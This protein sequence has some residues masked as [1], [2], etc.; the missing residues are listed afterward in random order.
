[1]SER[2]LAIDAGQSSVTARVV[3]DERQIELPGVRTDSAL[4][5][6]LAD[7]V[8]AVVASVGSVGAVAIGTTGLTVDESDPDELLRQLGDLS[9]TTVLLA[10]DSITS[11]LGAVGDVRGAVVAVGTGVVTL[12]VGR[13]EIARV[14]GWGNLFGDAGSGYWIGRAAFDAVMREYDGRGPKTALTARIRQEFPDLPSA[15][16][17]LQGDP[18]RVRRIASYARVVD[19]LATE[20]AVARRICDDAASEL[21]VSVGAALDR[22]GES[23][24]ESPRIGAIGGVL[25]SQRIGTAFAEGIRSRWPLADLGPAVGVGLDGVQ[26]MFGLTPGS[27]LFSAV[28]RATRSDFLVSALDAEMQ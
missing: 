12:G 4:L 6:Q 8:R 15:Y 20:D 27:A 22:V 21:V 18:D 16:I 25:R 1:M 23:A 13:H 2:L 17:E 10:H 19:D 14:D 24:A 7:A 9:V 28:A 5:P 26:A 3:G 11:Y